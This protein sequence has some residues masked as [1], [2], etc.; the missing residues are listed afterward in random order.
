[1]KTLITFLG[2]GRIAEG[3]GYQQTTYRFDEEHVDTVSFFGLALANYLKPDRLIVLG[4]ASSM[5]DELLLNHAPAPGEVDLG[6]LI[7][8]VHGERVDDS[9]LSRFA[10]TIERSVG[11]RVSLGVIPHARDAIEQFG[12]V[13]RLANEVGDGDEIVLDVTHGFRHLPMIGLVAARYLARVRR[14]VVKEIYY[15]A[16]DM[17][18]EANES[19]VLR[20]SGLLSLLDWVDGLASYD[21]DGD[22]GVFADLL[23]GANPEAAAHLAKGAFHERINDARHARGELRK[24]RQAFRD[25]KL[26]GVEAIFRGALIERTDWVTGERLFERQHALAKLH[27]GKGDFLRAATLGFEA[28]VTQQI[29]IAEPRADSEDRAIRDRV[30]TQFEEAIRAGGR[31]NRTPAD[32]AYL[33]LRDLRNTL[34]HGSRP[35]RAEIQ[36]ALTSEH[37]LKTFIA[38]RLDALR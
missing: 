18:S 36:G 13:A 1:M 4:T 23:A 34:V 33:D 37:A 25:A 15:G 12:I 29:R 21:K 28:A 2:K 9:L 7:D 22:F 8:A 30:K 24:F 5:W 14:A 11:R 19:P 35:D 10:P 17:R 3:G 32:Q 16:F 20:L 27:A 26:G 38:D 31:R 6:A